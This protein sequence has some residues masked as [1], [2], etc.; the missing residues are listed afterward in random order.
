MWLRLCACSIK[1][2]NSYP[3]QNFWLVQK[4]N[5]A[6]ARTT[7]MVTINDLPSLVIQRLCL[8]LNPE[9]ILALS[10]ASK[11]L[12]QLLTTDEIWKR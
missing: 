9:D 1:A 3:V 12:Y 11:S 8:Y 7:S 2:L 6:Q 5:D 4:K 10:L